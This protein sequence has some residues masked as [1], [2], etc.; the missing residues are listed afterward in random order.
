MSLAVPTASSSSCEILTLRV[1]QFDLCDCQVYARKQVFFG[2]K[3]M[4]AKFIRLWF[5]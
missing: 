3:C 1:S 4:M 5:V 2:C